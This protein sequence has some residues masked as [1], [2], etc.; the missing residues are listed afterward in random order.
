MVG[1]TQAVAKEGAAVGAEGL[2]KAVVVQAD[3]GVGVGAGGRV[4]AYTAEW[5]VISRDIPAE[6][7][8]IEEILRREGGLDEDDLDI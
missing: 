4:L 6:F 1:E 5:T 8:R 3:H 2:E 7:P